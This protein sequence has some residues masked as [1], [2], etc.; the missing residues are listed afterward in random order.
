MI[1]LPLKNACSNSGGFDLSIFMNGY[2]T[3][4]KVN[5]PMLSP[6]VQ[7]RIQL[8]WGS[9]LEHFENSLLICWDAKLVQFHKEILLDFI[10]I[11]FQF[12][13]FWLQILQNEGENSWVPVEADVATL[14]L[15]GCIVVPISNLGVKYWA[16]SKVLEW[17]VLE[18][19]S[20]DVQGHVILHLK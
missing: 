14:V 3:P 9:G 13:I 1:N 6:L 15:F 11:K 12:F 16:L 4:I 7:E 2:G 20:S 19:S 8:N 17:D 18:N 5:W 10:W